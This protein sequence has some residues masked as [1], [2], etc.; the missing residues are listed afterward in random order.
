[1]LHDRSQCSVTIGP[2]NPGTPLTGK[3]E[4]FTQVTGGTQFDTLSTAGTFVRSESKI[5]TGA[6]GFQPGKPITATIH[7]TKAAAVAES[8]GKTARY[9][10]QELLLGD[11]AVAFLIRFGKSG[12][13]WRDRL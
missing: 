3:L 12:A 8:T 6:G 4:R 2:R 11:S 1:M 10:V 13:Y 5:V 9:L 7:P